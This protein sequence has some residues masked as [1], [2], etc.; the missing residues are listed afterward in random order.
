MKVRVSPVARAEVRSIAQKVTADNG[1]AVADRL[2]STITAALSQLERFPELGKPGRVPGTRELGL[3][4]P[5]VIVYRIEPDAVTVLRVIHGAM[6]WP[7]V[8]SQ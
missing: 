2:T 8:S 1:P 6:Q 5:F 4:R 7:P 3:A